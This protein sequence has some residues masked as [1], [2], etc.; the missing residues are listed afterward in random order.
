M[1]W[2]EDASFGV[3][4]AHR[5]HMRDNVVS[6]TSTALT[7]N[8]QAHAGRTILINSNSTVANTFTLPA[9]SGTGNVYTL[10]NNIAQTQGT[11]VV[12][13]AGTD[14]VSGIAMNFGT[15]EETA[16]A[17]RTSATSDK[18]SLN[19]TTTGGGV[20]GDKVVAKDVASGTWLVEV[21]QMGSG[22]LVILFFVI[23]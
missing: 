6:T 17:F 22:S 18:I 21:I 11:V 2:R 20:G 9:A 15:T 23:V 8:P 10:V 14:V 19:L 3:V 7:L 12:A 5:V 16:M 1:A 4:R 13:A